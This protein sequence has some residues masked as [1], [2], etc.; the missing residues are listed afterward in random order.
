[1]S[2]GSIDH[3]DILD[4]FGYG[5]KNEG[6]DTT[7]LGLIFVIQTIACCFSNGIIIAYLILSKKYTQNS[8]YYI[9]VHYFIFKLIFTVILCI[10]LLMSSVFENT[11]F[12]IGSSGWLCKFEFFSNMFMETCENY[13]IFF[14]WLIILSERDLIGYKY[15]NREEPSL[16]GTNLPS[17]TIRIW[18]RRNS[19]TIVLVSH[20]KC[21]LFYQ[22]KLSLQKKIMGLFSSAMLIKIKNFEIKLF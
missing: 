6:N 15:L 18:C 9:L 17:S 3:L 12:H 22:K 19:R 16:P 21:I 2:N 10:T 13:L 8:K 1:M 4:D 20:E 14:L 11:V 5:I 7:L